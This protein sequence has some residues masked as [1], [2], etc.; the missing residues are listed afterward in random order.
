MLSQWQEKEILSMRQIFTR[1]HGGIHT[2]EKDSITYSKDA[3]KANAL[4][5]HFYFVFTS[6]NCVTLLEVPEDLYPTMSDIEINI[7]GVFQLLNTIDPF[8][9]TGPDSLPPKLF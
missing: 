9:A 1:D 4:N 3:S 2:L 5:K 7:Q 8:K 6:D